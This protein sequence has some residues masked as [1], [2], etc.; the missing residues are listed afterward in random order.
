MIPKHMQRILLEEG[1]TTPRQIQTHG[2][3][4]IHKFIFTT[5]IVCWIHE[6]GYR[7]RYCY[8]TLLEA[9]SALL[10][11]GG[12]GDPPGEWIVRK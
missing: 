12:K 1:Y 4:A 7:Y 6:T 9:R 8:D 11:W 10:E 3:C 5:A 2:L